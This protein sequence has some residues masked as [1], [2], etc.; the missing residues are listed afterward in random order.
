MSF[1]RTMFRIVL[2]I[3]VGAIHGPTDT[4]IA[5]QDIGAERPN[6]VMIVIDDLNDWVGCLGGHPQVQTPHID[7]LA[8]RGVTFTNAHCQAPICNPSRISMLLGQLPS[9]T[10]HYFLTPGFR[11]VEV[12][13][14]AE[15]LFQSVRRQGYRTETMGKI[16]HASADKPSFDL[17]QRSKGIRGLPKKLHYDLPGSHPLWDWGQVD[18]PDEDQRDYHTAS[19]AAQRFPEL[20]K[21]DQ[22]FVMAVG[23]YLP[24]VPIYA[25]KKWFDLYPMDELVMPTVPEGDLDDVPPIAIEL[26][27]NMTAPRNEWMIENGEDKEAVRAYLASIS[28]VDH[29]VGM[30]LDSVQK[31]GHSDDTLVVLLSDHGFHLAEKNKWAKRSLWER[32]TRVPLL[33]AGP[34]IANNARCDAPVGLIDVYPTLLDL[35]ALPQQENLDGHSLRPLLEDVQSPWQHPAI[36]TFGPGNH[37]VHSTDYHFIR[38]RDGSEELYDRRSDR[39]EQYNLANDSSMSSVLDEHRKWIPQNDA[40]MVPGSR[41]SDSPLYGESNGLQKAMKREK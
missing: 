18:F 31:S 17:A 10:G 23:F 11:D 37:S 3:M 34:G 1:Q 15:T 30:V 7:S 8:K 24:H 14:N 2:L 13:R 22:P 12:T 6:V 21:A 33:V 39:L 32:T 28:F 40:P 16:F 38:Y 5:Q 35:C 36:C 20:A 9:T 27:K 26:S 29:L 25:S 19:W 4:A 41:G